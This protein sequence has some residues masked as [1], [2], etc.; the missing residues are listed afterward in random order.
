MTCGELDGLV[1]PFIDG[2]CREADRMA[3]IAH[4]RQCQ[5]CRTRVDAESTAKHVLHAHATV[6]R[7]MGVA[8]PWRPRVFRL[9][10]P[11]LP[12][13][14]AML[15]LSAVVGA[16][17]LG[18]WLRPTPVIAVGVVGD[19]FCQHDHRGFTTRFN[20]GERECTL[21]CVKRGA[22]FV[23]VTDQQVYRIRNQQLPELAAFA[24]QSVKVE[25]TW[26]GDRIVVAGMKAINAGE[27]KHR[28][29]Q[30]ARRSTQ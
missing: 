28:L 14:P 1:T 6:A 12:V 24:N 15:L 25:G 22:E 29:L 4:L 27:E 7:T 9:G 17:L 13:R 11:A 16:G 23:L 10:Q 26:D 21:G 2:E 5:A 19:S 3:I 18:F 20:V 30:G 8:P